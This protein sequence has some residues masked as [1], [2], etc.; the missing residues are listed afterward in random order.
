MKI[1]IHVHTKKIK[2]G[3]AATRNIT[4]EK[5]GDIIKETDVKILAV[6]NHNHFDFQQYTALQENVEGVC[7]VW[8][9]VELDILEKTNKAHLII[10]V[11]P[12]KAK[13]LEERVD[14][15]LNGF[16]VDNF[17]IDLEN[18]VKAFDDLSP[19]YIAHYHSKTPN[20][21]DQDVET[22]LN[23]VSNK[24]R[25]LKE[26]SNSISAGIYISHGHNSI[27]GSDVH[28]WDEYQEI[29]K[30]L[31]ELRL[32]V[33]SF[34]QFCLLLDKDEATINT[35]L[36]R[37]RR[38][39]VQINP[40]NNAAELMD[41]DIYNDIN[42]VFGSKGTGKT[43]ILKALSKRYNSDGHNTSVYES[44]AN[45]LEI[46]HDLKGSTF[47][48]T[49]I[50]NGIEECS[51][52]IA[53]I[54]TASDK[55]VTNLS[56]YHQYF[57][58]DERNKI[59]QK[60]KIKDFVSEDETAPERAFNDVYSSL[61][62]FEDFQEEIISDEALKGVV[63]DD[64]IQELNSVINKISDKLYSESDSRFT[65]FKTIELFN[66]MIQKFTSEVAKKTGRPEKPLKTG[67][68]EY[69]SNRI[70]IERKVNKIIDNI[71][72]KI[73]PK[74]YYVGH[75]GEK[76]DLYCQTNLV[77]QDGSFVNVNYSPVSNGVT[78]NPQKNFAR[79]LVFI[80]RNVFT[81]DLFKKI[82]DLNEMEYSETINGIT[83][84]L[85]FHRYFTLDSVEYEPSTGES[86]MVLLHNELSEEKSIYL[87]DEPE[88]SLG[89]DYISNVIV[90]L[91]KRACTK[92]KKS[93][94]SNT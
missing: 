77:V 94:N 71:S 52:E 44:N 40:F 38:E 54:R 13:T 12:D 88:K 16:T 78:K 79:Q 55:A 53:F 26:A 47:A 18:T 65:D 62:R 70:N 83:D 86:S 1:D 7:Q 33:D 46:V 75:L 9:G 80:K 90:P 92:R 19:I 72:I 43:D 82:D 93:N 25:V 2:Q 21:R 68:Q 3:D 17:K 49:A 4:P 87:I 22:L 74:I 50:E 35:I 27:Y 23:L 67:F 60:I 42:I 29:S 11:N 48:T 51:E 34:E 30:T 69:A 24:R 64:L 14:N 66:S 89:N 76:G 57:L 8:P 36:N 20:L 31:P 5:F 63:G 56:E 41:L 73:E 85:Q 59:S 6:T 32:P 10:I 37:K 39:T 81:N 84:L 45:K 15:V 28:K 58:K 61:E 91:L